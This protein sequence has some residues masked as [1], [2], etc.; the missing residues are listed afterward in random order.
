MAMQVM[1]LVPQQK[2]RKE[3]LMDGCLLPGKKVKEVTESVV[4]LPS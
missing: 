1:A 4:E 3:K 2:T